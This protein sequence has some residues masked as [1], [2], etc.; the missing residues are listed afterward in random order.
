MK[1]VGATQTARGFASVSGAIKTM[2]A[3]L[4]A[5]S[6]AMTRLGSTFEQGMANVQSVSK[7]TVAQFSGLERAARSMARV[8]TVSANDATRSMY[9][10]ASA[11][12]QVNEIMQASKPI[13]TLA[14]GT[15]SS[16]GQVSE[17]VVAAM[18]QFRLEFTQSRHVVDVFA[19]SIQ[20]SLL[21]MDRLT[22]SMK[23]VGPIARA[24]N[25]TLE[26]TA[27]ALAALHDAGLMGSIAGTT[28]RQ[29]LLKL[30]KPT[31]ELRDVLAGA[32]LETH[33]VV[34]VFKRLNDAGMSNEDMFRIFNV[35]AVNAALVMKSIGT[36]AFVEYIKKM[37]DAGAAQRMFNIQLDT[38][39]NNAIVAWNQFKDAALSAFAAVEPRLS[40]VINLLQKLGSVIATEL[41]R[42]DM[43]PWERM[44]ADL[45]MIGVTADK[46][47]PAMKAFIEEA[48]IQQLATDMKDLAGDMAALDKLSG[49]SWANNFT[50]DTQEA[51]AE[52]VKLQAE[53]KRVMAALD[54][55]LS[56]G[57]ESP[58]DAIFSPEQ[59]ANFATNLRGQI[60]DVQSELR[61]MVKGMGSVLGTT[62]SPALKG[63]GKISSILESMLTIPDSE[64]AAA[65]AEFVGEIQALLHMAE[66]DI[67][68]RAEFSET[69]GVTDKWVATM[70]DSL[71]L[72]Q[73]AFVDAF[74]DNWGMIVPK[75][76]EVTMQSL[77]ALNEHL[78]LG[79]TRAG[80]DAM[81]VEWG[82]QLESAYG[83]THEMW[84]RITQFISEGVEGVSKQLN[85]ELDPQVTFS[86][87]AGLDQAR[88]ALIGFSDAME[89]M[90]ASTLD[91]A[92]QG[93]ANLAQFKIM[94]GSLGVDADTVDI[95]AA[96]Y[97]L[98]DDI[99]ISMG[100]IN[101]ETGVL[102][103]FGEEVF[104]QLGIHLEATSE[105]V[106]SFNERLAEEIKGME[107]TF[108]QV[109]DT[110]AFGAEDLGERMEDIFKII[111]RGLWRLVGQML[112][113]AAQAAFASSQTAGAIA[114]ATA[115]TKA[116]KV[117]ESAA[118]S[119]MSAEVLAS[120]SWMGPA[121]P[122]AAATILA[123]MMGIHL[124]AKVAA[125][126]LSFPPQGLA[127]GGWVDGNPGHDNVPAMLTQG[128][129]VV[130]RDQAL[131]NASL[132][133]AMR[134]GTTSVEGGGGTNLSVSYSGMFYAND[135]K[136]VRQ[137][138]RMLMEALE[139]V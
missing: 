128:E 7:S 4:T 58:M 47:T 20:N 103:R 21:N 105:K 41:R 68:N 28:L 135:K 129:F 132:L 6:V 17:L 76:S 72:S 37:N 117:L 34:E 97:Q 33:G 26:E 54:T 95:A 124:G 125:F 64:K 18:K 130:P 86:G 109:W 36:D 61:D 39:K 123:T 84:E 55:K 52:L 19:A 138:A 5:A 27:A 49:R 3:A 90:S 102:T 23:Y 44:V 65:L 15:M 30:N 22:E 62:F 57:Q 112:I 45:E 67:A 14:G 13:M 133:E 83:I 40:A 87:E 113:A 35:R 100:L 9:A 78:D 116:A 77:I 56:G 126:A 63:I 89:G 82:E 69:K 111:T 73:E 8:T 46:S 66:T 80:L 96:F 107:G 108:L 71:G 139:D 93:S 85:V 92:L 70:A 134:D 59:M 60:A 115:K 48:R 104:A 12:L 11:G 136:Q 50:Q 32:R 98:A 2:T 51:Q 91:F 75:L 120:V 31:K 25:M 43:G 81:W 121:A 94:L 127:E 106:M 114:D 24:S 119:L 131:S 118:L 137:H 88:E 110:I 1:A 10:L 79:G 29:M 99:T 74:Q 53:L 38:L 42:A 101:E 122:A 16:V